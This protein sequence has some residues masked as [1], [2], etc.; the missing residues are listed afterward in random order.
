MDVSFSYIFKSRCKN[1]IIGC[2]LATTEYS[3]ETFFQ[4]QLVTYVYSCFLC[5]PL[6]TNIS[7]RLLVLLSQC[8][9]SLIVFTYFDSCLCMFTTVHV[10][11]YV[12]HS[13]FVH[14]YL[15]LPMFT[16][17]YLCLRNACSCLFTYVYLSL[18]LFIRVFLCLLVFT[19]I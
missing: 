12:Y 4:S 9:K 17:V 15:C 18:S 2:K 19:Y 16:P 5:L 8:Y 3:A 11:T 10:F 14:V 6:L 7:H 13:L 1:L